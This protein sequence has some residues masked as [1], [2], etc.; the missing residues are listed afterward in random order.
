[1]HADMKRYVSCFFHTEKVQYVFSTS[2]YSVPIALKNHGVQLLSEYD[3]FY[4][5]SRL[6]GILRSIVNADAQ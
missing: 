2:T 5:R 6:P 3:A 1:M 4:E